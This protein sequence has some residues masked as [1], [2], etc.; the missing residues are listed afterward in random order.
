[1]PLIVQQ[2]MVYCVS[3]RVAA[4]L[5]TE[6][7]IRMICCWQCVHAQTKVAWGSMASLTATGQTAKIVQL[8]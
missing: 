2:S 8:S 4:D 5:T 7:Q 6:Y 1:M 3:A